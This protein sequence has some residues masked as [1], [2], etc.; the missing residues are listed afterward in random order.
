[1]STQQETEAPRVIVVDTIPN[2]WWWSKTEGVRTRR[3]RAEAEADGMIHIAP[4]VFSALMTDAGWT[5]CE[6]PTLHASPT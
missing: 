1:M 6:P 4:E 3:L 5:P 2:Q